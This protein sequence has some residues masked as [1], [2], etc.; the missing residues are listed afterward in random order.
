LQPA[1]DGLNYSQPV[2][3]SVRLT[4]NGAARAMGKLV[5]VEGVHRAVDGAYD[6]M[7]LNDVP[8]GFLLDFF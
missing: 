6:L 7:S 3:Q 4:I 2:P 8:G 5:D 1:K